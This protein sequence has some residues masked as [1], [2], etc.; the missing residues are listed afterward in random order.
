MS[1]YINLF[2]VAVISFLFV[3]CACIPG[4]IAS[5]NTP[6]HARSYNVIG[7]TSATD[8]RIAILG[9]IPITKSNSTRDAIDKA[10]EN[11]HA[12]ALIDITV[13]NYT[14]FFILF[15]RTVTKVYAKGV[16]FKD[17]WEGDKDIVR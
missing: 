3:G 11:A 2:F 8:S 17:K 16:R 13:E 15:S 12:D 5:S 7:P 9:I 14:Q 6:L 10:K 4:G 1:K